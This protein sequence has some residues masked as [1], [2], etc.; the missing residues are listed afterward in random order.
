MELETGRGDLLSAGVEALVNTVNIKGVMG[1]G[2]ALQFKK[3]FPENFK[4]YET[5]CMAD[6]LEPGRMFV[7]EQNL[8][9]NPRYIVNFPTKRHWRDRS[10]L[11]DVEDGLKDLVRVIGE[12]QVHSIAIPALGCGLGGLEWGEVEPLIVSALEPI[13]DLRVLLYAPSGDSD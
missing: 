3:R 1:K 13:H 8:S 2:L 10:R 5:A 6:E 4:A 11:D 9:S 7:F 12:L